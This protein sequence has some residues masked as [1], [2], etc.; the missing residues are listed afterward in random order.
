MYKHCIFILQILVSS[1]AT[2]AQMKSCCEPDGVK[3]VST[4]KQ[5]AGTLRMVKILDSI[6]RNANP[7]DFYLMNNARMELFKKKLDAEKDPYKR[8]RLYFKYSNEALNA[9]KTDE[10]ITVLQWGDNSYEIKRGSV[11]SANQTLF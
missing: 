6:G 8:L 4:V 2:N 11:K 1:L 3:L 9:G 5:T 10:A 7:E